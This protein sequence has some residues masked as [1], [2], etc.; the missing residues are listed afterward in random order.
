MITRDPKRLARLAFNEMLVPKRYQRSIENII[1]QVII[2]E[3]ER[4]RD[5][6][7]RLALVGDSD[8]ARSIAQA[9]RARR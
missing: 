3:R 9:I 5:G 4:E 8:E 2:S 7:A 6:C 1:I